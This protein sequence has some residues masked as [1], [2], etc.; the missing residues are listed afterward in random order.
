MDLDRAVSATLA[1]ASFFRFP[2]FPVEIHHWLIS[3][4]RVSLAKL[5]PLLPKALSSSNQ[6]LRA[7]TSRYTTEKI[8]H[9][10]KLVS[11]LKHFPGLRLIALTGSV[12]ANNTRKNDDIDLLFITAPHT[13]W[14]VRPFV[15]GLISFYFRRRHPEESHAHAPNA[16][17]PNLWLDTISLSL[18]PKQQSLYTAHEV[19]QI[20]PLFDRGD[21]YERFIKANRWTKK[22]LANAYQSSL[23]GRLGDRSNLTP[24]KFF[25]PIQQLITNNYYLLLAPLNYLFYLFQLLYMHPKKTTEIVHLHGAFLHTT[26]FSTQLDTHLKSLNNI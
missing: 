16:F 18:P 13:L 21:T 25:T 14:L 2:L 9:A 11:Y 22:Y 12:A 19:L 23:R 6:K 26:N 1:Y 5:R 24:P 4:Y 20:I 7:A 17:C 15:I 8:I 3:P 10:R